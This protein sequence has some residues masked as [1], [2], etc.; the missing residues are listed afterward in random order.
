[1]RPIRIKHFH[2]IPILM[3]LLLLLGVPLLLWLMVTGIA[4]QSAG[5]TFIGAIPLTAVLIGLSFFWNYGITI[6]SKR[7]T[8]LSQN[9][10]KTFLYEDVV[11]IKIGFSDD[12]IYGTIK[13]KNQKAYD[14]Y[15]GGIDLNIGFQWFHSRFLESDLR[16]TEQFVKQSI[17]KLAACGK[18]K[19]ENCY[20]KR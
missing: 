8:L 6:T 20:M 11:Y 17:E 1:M 12:S 5:L 9:M 18:V 4:V 3:Q 19:I 15:F 16:I 2:K 7:V 13:A 14:F 10:W